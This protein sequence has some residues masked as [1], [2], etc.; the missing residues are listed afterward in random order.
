MGELPRG[1]QS[2]NLE[3]SGFPRADD[4]ERVDEQQREV[5][6]AKEWIYEHATKRSKAGKGS[7][8][9]VGRP[10]SE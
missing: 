7:T 10:A 8:F 3:G 1:I 5:F 6:D 2:A 9:G 4:T